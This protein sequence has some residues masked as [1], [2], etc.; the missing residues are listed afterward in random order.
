MVTHKDSNFNERRNAAANAK[1]AAAARFRAQPG[2]SDPAVVERQAA[3]Q[4]V[5]DARETRNAERKAAREADAARQIT[6]E[7]ARVAEQVARDA[8]DAGRKVALEAGHKAARDARYA[9]R[10]ARR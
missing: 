9:A 10:K 5:S 3:L 1:Q 6:E 8:E 4:A 2:P 7:T